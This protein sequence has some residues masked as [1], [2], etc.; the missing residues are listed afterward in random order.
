LNKLTFPVVRLFIFLFGLLPFRVIYLISEFVYVLI[1]Y[2]IRYRKDIV[3]RNLGNS[4]PEKSGGEISRIA[5]GFYHH[6]SDVMLESI[7]SFSMSEKAVC[8]RYLFTNTRVMNRFYDEG[9]CVICVTGHY[10][11]WE[12]GGIASGL[13]LKHI[14]VGFYKP[15][16]NKEIDNYLQKTRVKGRSRLAS[17]VRT[18]ET[19]QAYREEPAAFYMIADQRPSSARFA[20]W[21]NFMNQ[22]TPVLHGPEKY[23]R[24]Y[25]YPVLYVDVQKISRGRYEVEFILL[26]EDPSKTKTGEITKKF[27]EILEQKIRENPQYYLWSHN[28]WK[29]TRQ[30]GSRKK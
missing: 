24:I 16:S 23:A 14:P 3:Y 9:K 19:F 5:H 30:D 10:N 20:Y 8:E 22:D 7:K 1:Y 29:F 13:Q 25:N 18:A 12:W 15:L 6:F 28:R 17:I 2:L 27:M 26:T 4:F 21:M 11:N